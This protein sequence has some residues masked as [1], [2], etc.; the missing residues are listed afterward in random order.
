MKHDWRLI[1]KDQEQV[2]LD[3]F[4]DCEVRPHSVVQACNRIPP[5]MEKILRDEMLSDGLEV[6]ESVFN[7]NRVIQNRKFNNAVLS[8]EP[9]TSST[10]HTDNK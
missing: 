3:S 4:K 7:Y 8:A 2:W 9:T 1:P 6:D 10:V 5:L